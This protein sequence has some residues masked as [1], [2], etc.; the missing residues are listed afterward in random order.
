MA[1]YYIG[2][3]LLSNDEKKDGGEKSLSAAARRVL[4]GLAERSLLDED[5]SIYENGRLFFP[6]RSADFSISHSGNAAAVS[7]VKGEMEKGKSGLRTGCDIQLIKPRRGMKDI[8][9]EFFRQ[10]EKEYIFSR[11]GSFSE[12]DR[13]F[14]IWTLKESY[15]K[16]RGLSVFDMAKVPSFI[17]GGGPGN[18]SGPGDR[19][20][21]RINDGGSGNG[22]GP[23]DRG[24]P[25]INGGA[26]GDGGDPMNSAGAPDN[27]SAPGPF[28]FSFNAGVS[29]PLAFYLYKLE[30][31][32]GSYMLASV[33]EGRAFLRPKLRWFS[34]SL[35]PESSIAEIKAAPSPTETVKPKM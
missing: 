4:S 19:G 26:P 28:Q 3:C 22:S 27:R 17:C 32:E 15:I 18:G 14:Q 35:L 5:I 29:S 21:L 6:D 24:G 7:F 25:S 31:P 20:G 1:S 10:D 16:L 12:T 13:F 34:Q 30:G 8:A 9:E 11:D 33:I 23:G 2:L